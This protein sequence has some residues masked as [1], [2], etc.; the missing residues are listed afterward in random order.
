LE[1]MD[2]GSSE[3]TRWSSSRADSDADKSLLSAERPGLHSCHE[4]LWISL[5]SDSALIEAVGRYWHPQD[6]GFSAD[7]WIAEAFCLN[8][9]SKVCTAASRKKIPAGMGGR[10]C[11]L[12]QPVPLA[13]HDDSRRVMLPGSPAWARLLSA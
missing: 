5:A 4:I 11:A 12:R 9:C 13:G 3:P 6:Q 2:D 7:S 8:P 1:P 10:R